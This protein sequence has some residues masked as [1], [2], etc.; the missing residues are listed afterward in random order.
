MSAS[1]WSCPKC[2]SE[3]VEIS[4]RAWYRENQNHELVHVSLDYE[5]DPIAWFCADCLESGEGAPTENEPCPY[6][7]R[8]CA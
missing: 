6:H 2:E 5:S 3:N 4:L 7:T 1:R 8:D